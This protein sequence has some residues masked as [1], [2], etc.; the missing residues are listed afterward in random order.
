[1]VQDDQVLQTDQVVQ[2]DLAMH[3]DQVL[4]ISWVLQA[5]FPPPLTQGPTSSMS[6]CLADVHLNTL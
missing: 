6:V 2:A 5:H 1:M 3:T 4:W